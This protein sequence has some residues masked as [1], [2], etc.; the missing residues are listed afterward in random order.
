MPKQ[1]ATL[2]GGRLQRCPRCGLV[3]PRTPEHFY[4]A[5]TGRVTG[6]CRPCQ[7]AWWQEHYAAGLVVRPPHYGRDWRRGAVGT[8]PERYKQ[9]EEVPA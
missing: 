9:R 3:K 8:P 6:Y 1:R 7:A 5:K 2:D 4:F